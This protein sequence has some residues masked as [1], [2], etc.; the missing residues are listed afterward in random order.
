MFRNFQTYVDVNG[1]QFETVTDQVWHVPR[2]SLRQKLL[3]I[4]KPYYEH[5]VPSISIQ[6][7]IRITNN[8]HKPLRFNFYSF[9]FSV[10]ELIGR[11][12]Q[13][14]LGGYSMRPEGISNSDLPLIGTGETTSFLLNAVIF[15][16]WGNQF[17][18]SIAS[19]DRSSF[20][21]LQ[22]LELGVY[23]LRFN[24]SN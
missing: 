19:N 22:P 15:W 21:F 1:V 5:R 8:T 13:V 20:W 4:F 18:L 17:G 16:H 14:P 23:Q 11:D 24:Y 6:L 7:G 3:G 2:K 12:G 10:P 9:F